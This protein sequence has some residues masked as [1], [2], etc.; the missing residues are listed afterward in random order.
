MLTYLPAKLL[1][2][3]T[4]LITTP[5]YTRLFL[6]DEYGN[7]AL[8]TGL[9]AFLYAFSVSG[10]G[11]I[12]LRFFP[13]YKA[14]SDL[15]VFFTNLFTLIGLVAGVISAISIFALF[16]LA[17]W[18]DETLYPLLFISIFV[19]AI[20]S[21]FSIFMELL[22][23]QQNSGL[24]AR[25]N[26]TNFYGSVLIGL[27]LVIVFGFGVEGLM[28]GT[29]LAQIMLLPF[30]IRLTMKG[31]TLSAAHI[32]S[33]A[34]LTFWSFAW[35]LAF[36]NT[37]FWGLRLSDR[38]IIE[39]FRPGFEVGLYSAT[40]NITD[41]TINLL[42]NI[43]V[44]SMG[45]MVANTWE[46]RGRESTEQLIG[47]LTRVFLLI[48]LPVTVGLSLLALPFV[49]LLTGEAY[50]AGHRIVGF[51]AFSTFVWGLSTIAHWGLVL[52]NKTPQFA[53]NQLMAGAV[54]IGLNLL[55][56][57]KYGYTIAAV[58][59]LMGYVL[60]LALQAHASRTYL[61]WKIPMETVSRVFMAVALMGA[62]LYLMNLLDASLEITVWRVI[63]KVAFGVLIYFSAL[64]FFGEI[65]NEEKHT[66]TRVIARITKGVRG[67]GLTKDVDERDGNKH[68]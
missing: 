42:V 46:T 43:F 48:C 16:F 8:A 20:N 44:L 60:L 32:N 2:A 13:V 3:L 14:K 67:K 17:P 18:I 4:S 64:W 25:L 40:Y 61:T 30:S 54:N 9:T 34:M 7:W 58:T 21:F 51:V 27:T 52:N 57:P 24:Y 62:G 56:V 10:L 29:L 15:N 36:G 38:F 11:S 6:P 63:L 55:L 37:A 35:P 33:S 49:T 68:G 53:I 41:R 19:F 47:R 1:P 22:R 26:L 23:V 31:T 12:V 50:H 59:T 39:A 66:A 5:I 45:P 65:T 28:Y